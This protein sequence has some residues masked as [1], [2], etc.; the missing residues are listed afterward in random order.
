MI[1]FDKAAWHIDAGEER[2][3]VISK[4]NDVFAFLYEKNLLSDDGIELYELGIDQ[5]CSLNDSMVTEEGA[6]FLEKYYDQIINYSH[7]VIKNKLS[8]LY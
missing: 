2:D 3:E 8:E 7:E 6:N 5:S 1:I 4:F